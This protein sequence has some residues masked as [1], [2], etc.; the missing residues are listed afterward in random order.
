MNGNEK[1]YEKSKRLLDYIVDGGRTDTELQAA[2][3]SFDKSW[4]ERPAESNI[5]APQ[6]VEWL[7]IQM[8]KRQPSIEANQDVWP[9][10]IEYLDKACTELGASSP[11]FPEGVAADFREGVADYLSAHQAKA[12]REAHLVEIAILK[13]HAEIYKAS[14]QEETARTFADEAESAAAEYNFKEKEI[15]EFIRVREQALLAI[16]KSTDVLAA[17]P[18]GDRKNKLELRIIE[19]ALR[20]GFMKNEEGQSVPT[21]ELQQANQTYVTDRAKYENELNIKYGLKTE[22]ASF[23]AQG[24]ELTREETYE[25]QDSTEPPPAAN[26]RPRP[27]YIDVY[28]VRDFQGKIAAYIGAESYEQAIAKHAAMDSVSLR[29]EFPVSGLS[30]V[31]KKKVSVWQYGQVHGWRVV[32]EEITW[33]AKDTEL[34]GST[35]ESKSAKIELGASRE[36]SITATERAEIKLIGPTQGATLVLESKGKIEIISAFDESSVANK[37]NEARVALAESAHAQNST[38][39]GHSPTISRLIEENLAQEFTSP[40][41][42]EIYNVIEAMVMNAFG[43]GRPGVDKERGRSSSKKTW[44]HALYAPKLL[45]LS[46]DEE[47]AFDYFIHA[48]SD[49]GVTRKI[50]LF[51]PEKEKLENLFGQKNGTLEAKMRAEWCAFYGAAQ[52]DSRSISI[53]ILPLLTKNDDFKAARGSGEFQNKTD[54]H[55]YRIVFYTRHCVSDKN[56]DDQEILATDLTSQNIFGYPA[57]FFPKLG[58]YLTEETGTSSFSVDISVAGAETAIAP[59]QRGEAF[60]PSTLR[61]LQKTYQSLKLTDF[62]ALLSQTVFWEHVFAFTTDGLPTETENTWI[63]QKRHSVCSSEKS[64]AS[65]A[66]DNGLRREERDL[67]SHAAKALKSLIPSQN[68]TILSGEYFQNCTF[69]GA[70]RGAAFQSLFDNRFVKCNGTDLLMEGNCTSNVFED[71]SLIAASQRDVDLSHSDLLPVVTPV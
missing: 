31:G 69:T 70:Y 4:S 45:T 16:L 58:A 53:V 38:F 44:G 42:T 34:A 22:Q 63:V 8:K 24:N 13:K 68:A 39:I 27:S 36:V 2:K 35:F 19:Q 40:K 56:G 61:R 33:N 25:N 71:C 6:F 26:P 52:Q 41:A 9:K 62:T 64:S 5:T 59:K 11:D 37:S 49:S 10:V 7:K 50:N 67:I 65:F 32:A 29:Q 1:F 17:L 18:E 60:D 46:A 15:S 51:N 43:L 30:I 20:Y 47:G 21:D 23:A 66:G 57:D 28:P 48:L 12:S 54:C 14:G 55:E 3:S